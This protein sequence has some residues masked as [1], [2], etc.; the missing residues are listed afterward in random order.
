M[1]KDQGKFPS[2]MAVYAKI[3]QG[4]SPILRA[5]VTAIIESVNGKTVNLELLD[6]GAG[7]HSK[8]WKTHLSFPKSN[9]GTE[10]GHDLVRTVRIRESATGGLVGRVLCFPTIPVF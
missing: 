3:H 2:P 8:D 6:N 7:N 5:T 10:G 1:S 4:S 9:Q